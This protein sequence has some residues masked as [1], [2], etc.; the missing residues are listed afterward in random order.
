MANE[1]AT[2]SSIK[3]SHQFNSTFLNVWLNV[4]FIN[5]IIEAEIN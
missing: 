3:D 4:R 1:V 2:P 5:V